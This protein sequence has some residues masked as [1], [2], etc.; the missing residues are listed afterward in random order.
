[1]LLR[2]IYKAQVTRASPLDLAAFL[3]RLLEEL[4]LELG[5]SGL[6]FSDSGV[7]M[8]FG[9]LVALVFITRHS[10][11]AAKHSGTAPSKEKLPL[12]MTGAIV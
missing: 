10:R 4:G 8:G 11:I 3:D 2:S 5:K 12:T 7:G 6:T 9:F 1:M